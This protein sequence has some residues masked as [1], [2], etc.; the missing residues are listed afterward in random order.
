[1]DRTLPLSLIDFSASFE[2]SWPQFLRGWLSV[3]AAS[4]FDL[5]KTLSTLLL[6]SPTMAESAKSASELPHLVFVYGT[7]KRG[8]PNQAQMNSVEG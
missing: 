5:F 2:A 1:M 7:L 3:K 4:P 8:E 6:G